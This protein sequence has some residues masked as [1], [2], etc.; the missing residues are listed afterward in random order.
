MIALSGIASKIASFMLT[1]T[2]SQAVFLLFTN[3][4]LILVG[5]FLE[6]NAGI[7]LFAPILIPIAQAYGIDLIHFGAILLLNLEIGLMTPPFAGNIFVAC[8]LTGVPMD[9][10]LPKMIPFFGACLPV[11]LITTY[12]PSFSLLI[13]N[14][15]H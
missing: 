5:M 6:T 10:M 1:V 13:P 12:W 9:K 8:K 3:I 7:L 4:L 11:L 2:D 15:L 14:L